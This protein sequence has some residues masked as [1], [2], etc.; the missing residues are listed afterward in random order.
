MN[1]IFGKGLIWLFGKKIASSIIGVASGTVVGAVGAA[2]L[3]APG[4]PITKEL[5]IKG[6]ISGLL[7]AA[8]GAKG[9]AHGEL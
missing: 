1:G 5:L 2:A 9:R 3:V 8:A 4:E 6:A 7:A